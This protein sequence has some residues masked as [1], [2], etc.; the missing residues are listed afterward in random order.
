MCCW[1]C[2]LCIQ[3]QGD[4]T[5]NQALCLW[6]GDVTSGFRYH[7][8]LDGFADRSRVPFFCLY[9]LA[10]IIVLLEMPCSDLMLHS[11]YNCLLAIAFL[12][13]FI[14]FS[15]LF[16]PPTVSSLTLLFSLT[17]LADTYP[18]LISP[19]TTPSVLSSS[20]LLSSLRVTLCLPGRSVRPAKL[21]QLKRRWIG[22]DW[23]NNRVNWEWACSRAGR[24]WK[25]NVLIVSKH[26]VSFSCLN[27]AD[28]LCKIPNANV[29][30]W[31]S[32]LCS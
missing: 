31:K 23:E 8:S 20:C 32:I 17:R 10:F 5:E 3:V 30:T 19:L 22:T 7:F 18:H 13:H 29:F 26:C 1:W 4:W 16:F 11:N 15:L 25:Q 24:S 6:N 28:H 9:L 14:F 2:K 21:R 12:L 27:A